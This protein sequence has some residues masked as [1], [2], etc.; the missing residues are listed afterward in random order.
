MDIQTWERIDE[1]VDEWMDG[2]GLEAPLTQAS[3]KRQGVCPTT[4]S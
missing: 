3:A 1:W 2:G 4:T